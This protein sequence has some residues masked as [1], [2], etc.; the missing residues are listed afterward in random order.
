MTPNGPFY[1]SQPDPT[2]TRPRNAFGILLGFGKAY[3]EYYNQLPTSPVQSPKPIVTGYAVLAAGFARTRLAAS[4]SGAS[5]GPSAMP[6]AVYGSSAGHI[7]GVQP[8]RHGDD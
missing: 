1:L 2:D 5:F 6:D 4:E 3:S 7:A 8:I